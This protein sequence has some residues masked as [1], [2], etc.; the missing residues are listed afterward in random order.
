[1]E[2]IL[3]RNLISFKRRKPLSLESPLYPEL[4][5]GI[6]ELREVHGHLSRCGV[7]VTAGNQVPDVVG[8]PLLGELVVKSLDPKREGIINAN[9]GLAWKEHAPIVAEE[10]LWV[11]WAQLSPVAVIQKCFW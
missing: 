3:L 11:N 9:N 5:A 1:M 6:S 7:V 4:V 2:D 8:I 10:A